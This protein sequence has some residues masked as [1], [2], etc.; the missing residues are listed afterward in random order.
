MLKSLS[1]RRLKKLAWVLLHIRVLIMKGEF[2]MK[3]NYLT[4]SQ[5]DLNALQKANPCLFKEYATG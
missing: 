2:A 4:I 5:L 1:F 3:R